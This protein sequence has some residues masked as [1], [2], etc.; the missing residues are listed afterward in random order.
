MIHQDPARV[1]AKTGRRGR[2]EAI[3]MLDRR[4]GYFP[5][6]FRWHGRIYDVETVDRCWTSAR[7]TPRMCFRV[8]CRE[9]WFE[10][11]QDVRLNRWEVTLV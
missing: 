5:K 10:L 2:R 8:R 3:E 9:G 1:M 4:F 11:S 7:S 6:R